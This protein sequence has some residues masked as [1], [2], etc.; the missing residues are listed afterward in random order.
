MRKPVTHSKYWDLAPRRLCQAL[1]RIYQRGVSPA[2]KRCTASALGSTGRSAQAALP[3]LL[4]DFGSRDWQLR[5]G[6]VT[7]VISIG[8]DPKMLIPALEPMLKDPMLEIQ[9]NAA[10]ALSTFGGR[11]RPAA[12]ALL[13]ALKALPPNSPQ[14]EVMEASLW[15]IAPETVGKPLVV[16]DA[17]PMLADGVTTE[18]LDA[19]F[20]GR[21]RRLLPAGRTVPC[22]AELRTSQTRGSITLYRIADGPAKEAHSYSLGKFEFEVTN[23][24]PSSADAS[25]SVFCVIA[26]DKIMLCARDNIL[27]EC[28]EIRPVK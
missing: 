9:G 3:F 1:I 6:S 25:V 24:P 5:F 17:T 22:N 8:G 12:P 21:R 23:V 14:K 11:A 2:S 26:A 15:R 20:N 4:K 27:R 28:L 13:E 18:A 7:A 16:A 10:F 19:Q